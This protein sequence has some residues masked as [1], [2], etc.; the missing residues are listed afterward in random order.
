MEMTHEERAEQIVREWAQQFQAQANGGAGAF[1]ELARRISIATAEGSNAELKRRRV[2]EEARDQLR[3][4]VDGFDR[5]EGSGWLRDFLERKSVWSELTFGAGQRTKGIVA[6][7][8]KE[9][10]E[11]EADPLDLMEWIDVANLAMDG[12][13]RAFFVKYQPDETHHDPHGNMHWRA[14]AEFVWLI[15]R[16]AEINEARRWPTPTS[17]DLPV[18]HVREAQCS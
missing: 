18:E 15:Q 13:W 8:R 5:L 16:K 10:A 2:V 12:F 3:R 11:I 17:D 14:A 6:H 7:I 1:G 4:L 9:L